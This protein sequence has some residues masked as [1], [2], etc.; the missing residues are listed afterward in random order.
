MVERLIMKIKEIDKKIIREL[1]NNSRL[2]YK[3]LANKINSRKEIVAY[4]INKME[5]LG[6]IKKY[7]PVFS[8][9][10]LGVFVYKIYISF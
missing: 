10:K 1:G 4:H 6:I 7:I 3:E 9:A 8:Q 2:S 5:K